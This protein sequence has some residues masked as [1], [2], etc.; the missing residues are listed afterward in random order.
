M[1]VTGAADILLLPAFIEG[2]DVGESL[3]TLF[4]LSSVGVGTGA[5]D[6]S[7]SAGAA[8]GGINSLSDLGAFTAYKA[9]GKESS[10]SDTQNRDG[11][12]V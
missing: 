6:G 7:G 5:G 12:M 1:T 2:V 11:L 3:G 10:T 4:S 9:N 8:G